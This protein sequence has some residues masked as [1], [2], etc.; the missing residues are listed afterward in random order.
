MPTDHAHAAKEVVVVSEVRKLLPLPQE[1]KTCCEQL[2]LKDHF[3]Y[4]VVFRAA[5]NYYERRQRQS[6][7]LYT[8]QQV[9]SYLRELRGEVED[10]S[11]GLV[12]H[13]TELADKG[14]C[15]WAMDTQNSEAGGSRL[16]SVVWFFASQLESFRSEEDII[17]FDNRYKSNRFGMFFGIFSGVDR[18]GHTIPLG[19][20]LSSEE[21]IVSFRWLFSQFSRFA[22]T[23]RV[24]FTDADPGM[25]AAIICEFPET[26][27][28][29]CQWHVV[30]NAAKRVPANPKF[31]G[32]LW[33]LLSLQHPAEVDA[34]LQRLQREFPSAQRYI[35][36]YL[37][38]TKE[39]WSAA[40][41]HHEFCASVLST[42]RSESVNAGTKAAGLTG[43][44]PLQE[45]PSMT[46]D[47]VLYRAKMNAERAGRKIY[48]SETPFLAACYHIG[49]SSFALELQQQEARQCLEYTVAEMTAESSLVL[50]TVVEAGERA[51]DAGGFDSLN[52]SVSDFQED[53]DIPAPLPDSIVQLARN[54][55]EV[56]DNELGALVLEVR[57]LRLWSLV[58][59]VLYCFF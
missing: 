24:I 38:K 43:A 10:D 23:P 15:L 46:Q 25:Q 56:A 44:R 47:F 48:V 9:R 58:C 19:F 39:K 53:T 57:S 7:S 16:R 55:S 50:D 21:T 28:L 1:V 2:L 13:L 4:G 8:P 27:H 26:L 45:F 34:A 18:H 3:P 59:F 22:G 42:Q 36:S 29:W 31:V 6:P 20:A 51:A 14:E 41:R 40:Y 30:Q 54:T 5:L 12:K 52:T 32:L 17:L 35:D 11:A 49:L 33:N 37:S